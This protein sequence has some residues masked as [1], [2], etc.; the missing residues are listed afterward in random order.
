[1]NHEKL[2]YGSLAVY[3]LLSAIGYV[4]GGALGNLT[5]ASGV[6]LL[7]SVAIFAVGAYR[8]WRPAQSG[9]LPASWLA[10]VAAAAA[11]FAALTLAVE[12]L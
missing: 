7:A 2:F 1:M 5:V 10:Y 4:L 8:L 9:E 12:L 6:A 11:V 3:G